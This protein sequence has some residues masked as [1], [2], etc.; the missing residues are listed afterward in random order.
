MNSKGLK[1]MFNTAQRPKIDFGLTDISQEAQKMTGKLSIPGV[2]PKLSV[3]LHRK[4]NTLVPVSE[5][6]AYILKPQTPAFPHIPE[7]EQCCM[8]IAQ[9][10]GVDVPPHCLIPLKDNS[11]AYVIKRFDRKGGEKIH[12]EDFAQILE[13]QD[14]YNGSVEQIGRRLKEV[15]FVPGLDVQ[16]FFERV[17][18]N[19]L[20][21]NGD[22][23]LKNYSVSY[24]SEGQVRLTPAYDLVCSKLV[25]LDEE[26]SALAINGKR[27]K[28]SREDFDQLAE[29]LKIPP[30]VRYEKFNQKLNIVTEIIQNSK[31]DQERQKRFTGIVKERYRRINFQ[32]S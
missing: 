20:I 19:F 4:K 16:L 30:K 6:G 12:Q 5:G 2:Q 13:K 14:K 7:N 11:W 31:I 1:A 28:L 10:L 21:G 25:I 23:H 17:V 32:E 29:Y 9:I 8:D 27:N 3:A 15:S 22:A 26:D 18:L 24:G